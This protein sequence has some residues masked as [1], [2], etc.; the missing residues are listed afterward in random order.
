MK[1]SHFR[2]S[3]D[4]RRPQV[5]LLAAVLGLAVPSSAVAQAVTNRGFA[6]GAASAFPL[7]AV[8]DTTRVVGDVLVREE[9]FLKLA[10][11]VQGAA[12]LDL[13]ANTHDQV[14]TRWVVDW[15]DR[16]IRRPPIAIR[17]LSATVTKGG[18]AV[19]VGKQ[20]IRWGKTDIVTPTDRFAP[21]DFLN[22]VNTEL[23][24]VTGIRATA[25]VG[26]DTVEGVWV[27]RLTPSRIPLLDQRWSVPSPGAPATTVLDG[28]A[29]VPVGSQVGVRWAHVGAG[30]EYAL[31]FFDGFNHLPT[32]EVTV[33]SPPSLVPPKPAVVELA[34][35]YPAIRSYGADTA[36]PTP[37]F[38]IKGEAA[39]VTSASLVA[40]EYVLYAVQLERQTG[41]WTLIA[42]YAGEAVTERRAAQTF[43]PDRGM[44]RSAVARASY[45]IDANRSFAFE[46]VARQDGHGFYGK[47]EYSQAHGE[48]WRATMAVVG[49]GGHR[50]D[51]LGQYRRNSHV[52]VSLRYSF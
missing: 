52:S 34:R 46:G 30:F 25:T 43:A 19:D 27:P 38:T 15:S 37:W 2:P 3:G 42:G 50:D 49:L 31:S 17:R 28:G 22:V 29:V 12:G 36:I 24:A 41:E 11:W 5:L 13:R 1:T 18:I 44:T 14:E 4:S 35:V 40:D 21:R 51:F 48:H 8:N 26:G 23:L 7:E 16:G 45:T 6:E 32:I 9:L 10:P 33:R 20:F 47:A 39:Y